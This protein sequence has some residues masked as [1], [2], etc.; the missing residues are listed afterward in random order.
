MT[1]VVIPLLARRRVEAGV[2]ARVYDGLVERFGGD[3]ALE[4]I[5]RAVEATAE[6]AGREY[7]AGSPDHP[8]LYHFATV[9]E[10]WREGEALTVEDVRRTA[11]ALAFRVTRCAYV[12]LYRSLGLPARLAHA[13]SC[14]RD[15]AFARGYHPELSLERTPTLAQGAPACG[16]L[17]RWGVPRDEGR[18]GGG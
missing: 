2:L 1:G 3:V 10:R 7:A 6:E 17:F 16:F 4:V 8:T 15:A 14:G 5:G 9:L 18:S 11:D 12:E 13:L